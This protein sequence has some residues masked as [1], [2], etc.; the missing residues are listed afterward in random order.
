MAVCFST[1]APNADYLGFEA[2]P[3]AIIAAAKKAEEVGFDAIFVNDHVIVGDDA[4]SAPWTN[5]YDPL[6]SMS[7]IAAHTSHIGVGVSVLIMPYRNP[8]ATAKAMATLDR[9]SGGRLIAGIGIGWNETEFAALGVPFDERCGARSN[10][11]LRLWQAC[12]APGK[13]S[14]EGKFVS[15]ADMHVSPKPLQQPHP[16][17]W[18]GGSGANSNCGIPFSREFRA[19]SHHL[20]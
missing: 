18:I 8:I 16:P 20:I 5:V 13:V 11:Y 1:R 14:F 15:F 4:R 10:E 9:M 19:S 17:I 12:W 6:V 3:E 7:F 2:S